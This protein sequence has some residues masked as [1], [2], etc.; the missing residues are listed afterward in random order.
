[1][2]FSQQVIFQFEN[3]VRDA[4]QDTAA[5]YVAAGK[6]AND[7]AQRQNF[8]NLNVFGAIDKFR[9]EKLKPILS[10]VDNT[11]SNLPESQRKAAIL[12]QKEKYTK[13]LEPKAQE[14]IAKLLD[15]IST[16]SL[17]V[18]TDDQS[19][20]LSDGFDD[21]VD[22]GFQFLQE[23][24]AD[25]SDYT[26]TEELTEFYF[27]LADAGEVEEDDIGKLVDHALSRYKDELALYS[28]PAKVD[29]YAKGYTPLVEKAP[30]RPSGYDM[31]VPQKKSPKNQIK[32]DDDPRSDADLVDSIKLNKYKNA[33]VAQRDFVVLMAR[34]KGFVYGIL[35]RAG[36][37]SLESSMPSYSSDDI[38]QDVVI[39]AWGAIDKFNNESEISTWLTT[40]TK[41]RLV[42]LVRHERGTMVEEVEDEQGNKKKRQVIRQD[43]PTNRPS[44]SGSDPRAM[45]AE[46]FAEQNELAELQMEGGEAFVKARDAEIEQAVIHALDEYKKRDLGKN[47]ERNISIYVDVQFRGIKQEVVAEKNGLKQAAIS[48]IV[49]DVTQYL[50]RDPELRKL[51]IEHGLANSEDSESGGSRKRNPTTMNYD[52]FMYDSLV[53]DFYTNRVVPTIQSMLKSDSNSYD[54]LNDDSIESRVEIF[55]AVMSA[56]KNEFRMPLEIGYATGYARHLIYGKPQ[57]RVTS[58]PIHR[59]AQIRTFLERE[60]HN[61]G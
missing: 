31:G 3:T 27:G 13:A 53:L 37:R 4:V 58:L 26:T 24:G 47:A 46:S 50:I 11:I 16:A 57:P 51:A 15:R 56:V 40:I 2:S 60:L 18:D 54:S 61:H 34:N 42:S 10:S 41:N 38:Y 14:F 39:S 44:K 30:S 32:R 12:V 5:R 23:S 52:S 21:L 9:E 59:A 1:M 29:P 36:I 25:P 48:K 49:S 7:R 43:K 28:K 20:P 6:T 22:R 55:T 19:E 33:S 35:S 8:V 45:E 17:V